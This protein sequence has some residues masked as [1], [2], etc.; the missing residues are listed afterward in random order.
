MFRYSLKLFARNF[1]KNRSIN[2]LN[3]LGLAAGLTTCMLI[4]IFLNNELNY[5]KKIINNERIVRLNTTLI[6]GG[7]QSVHVPA[8]SYP[9]A[10]GL[11]AEIP[12][13]ESWTRF[14]FNSSET[15]IYIDDNLFLEKNI[16]WA[17]SNTFRVFN[18]QLLQGD[19]ETALAAPMSAV[20]TE[21]TAKKFF[22]EEDPMGRE[23]KLREDRIYN[24]TGVMEDIPT[25]SHLPN[26][27][28]Y[29]SLSSL[30]IAGAEYWVGRPNYCS[31]FLLT[32]GNSAETVQPIVSKV[33]Q[34]NAKE[35][36]EL[37]GAECSQE[38]QHLKDIHFDDSFDY[39]YGY[40]PTI[41]HQKIWMFL[42]LAVF[43]LILACVSFINLATA[44]S[45]E[46]V[47]QIG[48]SKAIGATRGVL[49]RQYIGES[50]LTSLISLAI[51]FL[52][53]YQLLPIFS[54]FVGRTL[55]FTLISN[56]PL[57]I[58]FVVLAI[59]VGVIAGL[60]P[61]IF[62]TSFTPANT[63]KG[64]FS[65]GTS[66]SKIRSGLILFQF[67]VSIILIIS[68]F[69]VIN[70][71]QFMQSKNPGFNK[72]HLLIVRTG[73]DMDADDCEL[74]WNE[75]SKK[76]EV[77]SVSMSSYMP[78]MNHMEYT[79]EVPEE[80]NCEK[81]MSR[82]MDVDHRFVKTM[83]MEIVAGRNF[84]EGDSTDMAESILINEMAAKKLGWEDPL[85]HK[86]D[87]DPAQGEDNF[88]PV[89]IVGVVKDINFQS[90]HHEILPMVLT[91]TSARPT[92]I[93][94]R[95]QGDKIEDGLKSI[96]SVWNANFPTAPFRYEFLDERFS[97][98][99]KTE[100][101]LQKM[102]SFFTILAILI[103]CNGLFALIAFS[104]E[105]QTKEIGIRKV[106]GASSW[107]LVMLL[108]K[109]YL[110]LVLIANLI[111]WPIAGYSMA[112]WLKSF[113]Y[114][115]STAYWI[116]PAAGLFALTLAFITISFIAIKASHVNPIDS[117]RQD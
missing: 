43:I 76:P 99:Y 28:M 32:E 46:R 55:N 36:L 110:I 63:I 115:A 114:K 31:Y 91:Y 59:V 73:P 66:R 78:S 79:Y 54:S 11:A 12:L 87:A 112:Q 16:A 69:T 107:S 71:L 97:K 39:N 80:A 2:L 94:F 92:K 72:D 25:P 38:L 81:L 57:T 10:P 49:I 70:Q 111:A 95:L 103:S 20:I 27:P 52:L 47:K 82:R 67:I 48:I 22:G 102:F 14:R 58:S 45:N 109:S 61:S 19:P 104:A 34:E 116:Y 8:T 83:E 3:L 77:L 64:H 9:I 86:L 35:V 98:E 88:M 108:T 74:L 100:I 42:G 75:V 33:Y 29:L 105:R 51:A 89:I 26:H 30:T 21:T 17:D 23:I 4:I 113:A 60:Y 6:V 5:D 84:Y 37:V 1:R 90:M 85:G 53:T 93:A 40:Q 15:P 117:L 101:Q 106:L 7:G 68:T 62:L 24:V 18:F 50:V 13:I 96:E 44:R 65:L 41:T 56:I